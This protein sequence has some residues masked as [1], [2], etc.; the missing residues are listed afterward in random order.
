MSRHIPDRDGHQP[1]P[2]W[3]RID[4]FGD[5][6][7]DADRHRVEEEGGMIGLDQYKGETP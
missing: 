7:S 1:F 5:V 6:I 2:G 4:A 3:K